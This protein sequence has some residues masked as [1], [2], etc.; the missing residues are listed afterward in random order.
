MGWALL[1]QASDW[2]QY[3]PDTTHYSQS[4]NHLEDPSNCINSKGG[5]GGLMI[6][7]IVVPC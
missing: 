4:S 3:H 7:D 6:V 5:G 1:I 2:F